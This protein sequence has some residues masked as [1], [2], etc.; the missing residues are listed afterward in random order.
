MSRSTPAAKAER[1]IGGFLF[2]L[3]VLVALMALLQTWTP[4]LGLDLRGGTTIQLTAADAGGGTVDP[5]SL[6]VAAN[7]ISQRVD[8]L[9]VGESSVT[10]QG[11]KQIEVSVPNMNGDELIDLVGSTAR[12]N[13]RA[14]LAASQAE[15]IESTDSAGSSKNSNSASKNSEGAQPRMAPQLPAQPP[16]SFTPRPTEPAAELAPIEKRL[17]YEPSEQDMSE[18]KAFKCGMD[19]PD[20]VDQPLI[21]C[22][23]EG[24]TKYLLGPMLVSGEDLTDAKAGIPRGQL[25]WIVSLSLNPDGAADFAQTSKQ[26]Y[27]QQSPRNQFAIVLDSKVVSA[28][29]IESV[30]SDG[31]AQ[32]SGENI[33]ETSAN[34]LASTLRY[35]ALPIDLEVSSVDTISPTLGGEQ[36]TAGIIAGC[37]GLGLVLL[38]AFSYYRGLVLVVLGSLVAVSLM[39]YS[40]MV[41]LGDIV[42]FALNLPGVAGFIVGIGMTA[43]SFIVYFERIRDEVRSGR[44]LRTAIETGWQKARN[45]ILM[46]DGVQLLAAVVLYF[47]SIGSVKGFA[48]TLGI[49]TGLDLFLIVFFT[50]PLLSIFGRTKFFGQGHKWSG[51]SAEHMGVSRKTLLGRRRSSRLAKEAA[52]AN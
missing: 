46:A 34:S 36:L 6:E 27:Q 3:V 2:A 50:H 35:G 30:I 28:P 19:F 32:I 1:K 18:F 21:A 51:F 9:G 47:L 4:R 33:N 44:P 10:I 12:L 22:D 49:T 25:N 37:I 26:L 13:F 45:A 17:A 24:Q 7:I 23:E 20:V 41:L 48:F 14:V 31:N 38:Y 40:V 16:E 11:D 5:K 43:D 8:G 42:G 39:T 29:R 52:N 15:S